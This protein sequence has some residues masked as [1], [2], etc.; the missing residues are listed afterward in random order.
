[1]S[2]IFKVGGSAGITTYVNLDDTGALSAVN[3]S[4]TTIMALSAAGDLSVPSL[5]AT[6]SQTTTVGVGAAA[7]TGVS[8][9]ELGNEVL[10]RTVLTL[11][12]TPV[13]MADEAGVVAYGS[14]KVYDL[15][16]GLINILGCSVNLALTLSAA[17]INADWDGDVS[18]GIAAAGNNATLSGPEAALV[19]STATPQDVASATTAKAAATTTEAGTV[20]DGTSAALDVYLNLL[21]DDADHDVTSTPTNIVCDGTITIVWA[22]LGD[23]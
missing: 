9:A 13:V 8:A 11:S 4:G 3:A 10:H 19:P 14:L 23:Y 18:L 16:E 21:V 6:T 20:G 22:F 17:G 12:S 15:P 7:G 5:T 1:M 2:T